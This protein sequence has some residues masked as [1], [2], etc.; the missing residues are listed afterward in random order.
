M[1]STLEASEVSAPSLRE[2]APTLNGQAE[3]TTDSLEREPDLEPADEV[4]ENGPTGELA[5]FYNFIY[6]LLMST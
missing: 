4:T 6:L 2:E 1:L 5:Y 3:S